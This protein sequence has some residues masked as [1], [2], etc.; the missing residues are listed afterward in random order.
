MKSNENR[1]FISCLAVH[2]DKIYDLLGETG[3]DKLDVPPF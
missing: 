2:K 3:V 1:V